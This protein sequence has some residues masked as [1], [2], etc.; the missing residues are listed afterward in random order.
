MLNLEA[1]SASIL[2]VKDSS[3]ALDQ[4]PLFDFLPF[5]DPVDIR[6]VPQ[7]KTSR[8]IIFENFQATISAARD[9]SKIKEVVS[10]PKDVGSIEGNAYAFLP[11]SEEE[12]K[13]SLEFSFS[14][15]EKLPG[16][17]G[18]LSNLSVTVVTAAHKQIEISSSRLRHDVC[19]V[20]F[21]DFDP[22]GEDLTY[23]ISADH[24]G[25]LVVKLIE[26]P[27]SLVT[28]TPKYDEGYITATALIASVLWEEVVL[29]QFTRARDKLLSA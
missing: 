7:I 3:Q 12:A 11:N 28:Q 2:T 18:L 21:T 5:K 16:S 25:K 1:R 26:D 8:D 27:D 14:R 24:D 10:P 13:V 6:D 4:G 19:S 22:N 23:E 9:F 17:T 15:H 29:P 20:H